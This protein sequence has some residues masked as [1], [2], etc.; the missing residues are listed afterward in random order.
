MWGVSLCHCVCVC[1]VLP[2]KLQGCGPRL[3][4]NRGR[5]RVVPARCLLTQSQCPLHCVP[6]WR[7]HGEQTCVVL[8]PLLCDHHMFLLQRSFSREPADTFGLGY[9]FLNR[10]ERR[11]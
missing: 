11:E 1:K 4:P 8:L 3:D 2:E 6:Q 5:G 9:L 10:N 7:L